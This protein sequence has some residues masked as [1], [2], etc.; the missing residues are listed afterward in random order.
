[1]KTPIVKREPDGSFVVQVGQDS[2]LRWRHD[3]NPNGAGTLVSVVIDT[4]ATTRWFCG[5]RNVARFN[6]DT[7]Q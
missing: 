4:P 7:L 1:M 2:Y 5:D 6:V 3:P